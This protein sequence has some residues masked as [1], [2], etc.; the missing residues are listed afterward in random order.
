MPALGMAQETGKILRWLKAEGEMLRAGEPVMEIETDKAV[1][2]IEAPA[3]G[4]LAAVRAGEGEDVPVGQAVALILAEGEVAPEQTPLASPAPKP[5][6]STAPA[7]ETTRVAS[8]LAAKI[9]AENNIDLAR[10]KPRGVRIE[11]EDVLRSIQADRPSGRVLAS[12]KA[13]RLAAERGLDLA[14]VVGSGPTGAVLVEDL[15][16]MAGRTQP[17]AMMSTTWRVMAERVTQSWT[18]VPHFY[19]MRELRAGGLIRWLADVRKTA[20]TKVTFTDLLVKLVAESLV[21][22]PNVNATWRDG[23]IVAQSEVNIGLA[24]AV[25]DGLVVPVINDAPSLD[26]EEI[27]ARRQALW[28]LANAGRLPLKDVQ[29]GTF[30]ISNLG[31]YG[32]DAFN[33]V[34]NAP[35]AAILAVGRIADRVVA[36]DGMAQVHPTLFV[37]LTCDHRVVDGARGA[38]FLQTLAEAVEAPPAMKGG[39]DGR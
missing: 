23:V 4:R 18:Q 38:Q 20:Q 33:A 26:L 12:P 9:A 30:T 31:M 17:A 2:E 16:Q 39:K 8:P 29:G 19:L 15:A 32:I 36:E 27:A 11:K 35:Q 24:M 34:L 10:V 1:L 14:G 25:E 21:A 22:H 13:R 37:S 5:R 6:S 28:A 3:S 7:A